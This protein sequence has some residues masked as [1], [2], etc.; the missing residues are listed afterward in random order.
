MREGNPGA[1]RLRLAVFLVAGVALLVYVGIVAFLALSETSMVYVSAGD[2]RRGRPVPETDAAIPWDTL[3][4]RAADGAP[5]FLLVSR[6]DTSATR[7]WA[8]FFHGNAGMV[9]SRSSVAR[10]ALLRDAGFNVLAPEYRGYG[11]AASSGPVSEAGVHADARAALA[12]L[13]DSLRLRSWRVLVYGWSL[14]SGPAARLAADHDLGALVTEGGFT[15]L[16]DVGAELYPWVPV[17]WIMRNRFDN[18]GL[19]HRISEPWIVFHGRR[20]SEIPF[21]HG[22]AIALAGPNARLVPLDADHDDGVIGDRGVAL[23]ELRTLAETL[24]LMRTAAVGCA[25]RA[26]GCRAARGSQRQ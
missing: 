22:E 19:A 24:R 2:G 23:G 13:T 15:S 20:D 25:L 14:G 8:I 16:P 6:V 4:V 5:V 9:G 12:Y 1:R 10:Y 21:A 17:G 11:A 26:A 3:R 7:P 18:V